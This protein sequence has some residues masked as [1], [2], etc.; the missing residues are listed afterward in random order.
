MLPQSPPK[1][2]N[3]PMAEAKPPPQEL[4][5]DPEAESDPRGA[6]GR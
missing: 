1:T 2:P 5:F 6:L 4:P 3:P